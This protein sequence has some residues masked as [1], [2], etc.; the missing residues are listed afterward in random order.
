MLKRFSVAI[1]GHP[2]S[3][4]KSCIWGTETPEPIATKVCM[5]GA[6]QDVITPANFCEDRLSGF[7]VAMGRILALSIDLLRRWLTLPAIENNSR[8]NTPRC[9]AT[10]QLRVCMSAVRFMSTLWF[11]RPLS[12]SDTCCH[13]TVKSPIVCKSIVGSAIVSAACS[14]RCRRRDVRH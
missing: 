3:T 5:P 11:Y 9:T 7:G 4:A 12:D 10:L 8:Y 1:F 13:G 14:P 6:V 2:K